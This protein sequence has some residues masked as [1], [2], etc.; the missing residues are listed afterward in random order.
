MG[1][2][3]L[4]IAPCQNGVLIPGTKAHLPEG[5][6]YTVKALVEAIPTRAFAVL[7]SEVEPFRL[8]LVPTPELS[9][10][11]DAAPW[12]RRLADTVSTPTSCVSLAYAA[13]KYTLR[14]STDIR[15][16]TRPFEIMD[17]EPAFDAAFNLRNRTRSEYS[18]SDGSTATFDPYLGKRW[19]SCLSN[20][21]I[22]NKVTISK[23]H[24]PGVAPWRP[25]KLVCQFG[26]FSHTVPETPD[27]REKMKPATLDKYGPR[28]APAIPSTP[29]TD[30]SQ[31][32]PGPST[33]PQG[34][35]STI[36]ESDENTVGSDWTCYV[37]HHIYHSNTDPYHAQD[38]IVCISCQ[39]LSQDV[40][41]NDLALDARLW[42]HEFCWRKE[43]KCPQHNN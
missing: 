35:L 17:Y 41:E 14:S 9:V 23:K 28:P 7:W 43:R 6:Q 5:Q 12:P 34:L 39:R 36:V 2:P 16:L 40:A 24:P 11:R 29:T 19:D 10:G 21:V 37:C 8:L 4:P 32:Q 22:I 26:A 25:N 31:P 18:L 33:A 3:P 20:S 1:Y 30:T 27:Y 42:A 13:M 38:W 15:T